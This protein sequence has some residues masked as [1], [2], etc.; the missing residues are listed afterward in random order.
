MD[1]AAGTIERLIERLTEIY[2]EDSLCA[3]LVPN[4]FLTIDPDNDIHIGRAESPKERAERLLN[5]VLQRGDAD[6][7]KLLDQLE[8]LRPRFPALSGVLER[9]RKRHTLIGIIKQHKHSKLTLR[10]I[11]DIGEENMAQCGPK[12][13]QDLPLTLLRKLAALERT[14][15]DTLLLESDTV[16]RGEETMDDIFGVDAEDHVSNSI[17]SLDVLCVLLNCSDLFLQQEI[18]SKMSLCQFAVPLLLPA[19]DGPECTFM[20]W[21]MR[22]IVRSWRPQASAGSRAF[23]EESLVN[24]PMPLFSFVR[25]GQSKLSKSKILNQVFSPTQQY[26]DFFIHENMA[27]GNIDRQLS[28]GLVEISWSFPV[29]KQT[30]LNFPEPI[31]VTN[32]HGNLELNKSQLAFLMQVSAAV[33]VFA[34]NINERESETLSQCSQSG[35]ELYF[36]ITPNGKCISREAAQ[37]FKKCFALMN[38]GPKNIVMKD[39]VANDAELV[40][41]IR[42]IMRNILRNPCKRKTLEDMS[43]SATEFGFQVDE[44]C[45][46]CQTAKAHATQITKEIQDVVQYKK[47]TLKLQG[48]LWKEVS[49]TEKELCRMRKQGDLTIKQYKSLLEKKLLELRNQQNRHPLPTGMTLF[50]SAITHFSQVEKHYFLKWMKFT[51]DSLTRK[52]ILELRAEYKEKIKSEMNKADK[53]ELLQLGQQISDSSLGIEHFLR[54]MGQFYESEYSMVKTKQIS[55]T[56]QFTDLP[57]VAAD[58]LLDGFPLELMD[59]DASNIPMQWVTGILTELDNKTGGKCRMRVISVLGVQSTGKSTLLNTMFGLQ[60]PVASGRCTRGAFMTLINVKENLV[61][62]L[63]CEFVLVIDTEGLKAPELASLED[64]YE[65]DNELAT[66]VV[67]L[68]DITITNIAG[69]NSVDMKDILQIVVHAFLRMKTI[70]EKPKCQFVHQNV[71]DVSAND[72]NMRDRTKILEQLNEMTRTAANMEKISGITGFHDIMDYNLDLDSW[73]IPGLWYGVPPM[74]SVSSGYSEN[75]YEL[76]KHLFEFMEKAKSIRQPHNIGDFIEWIKGL[77]N[78]VKHENFIFSF[79][80]S[81]VAEAYNHLAMK[82]S[83]WEWDFRKE[84]QTWLISTEN[85]MKNQSADKLQPGLCV[86]YKD[87]L[88]ILLCEEEKKM[89]DNLERYFESKSNNVHLIERYR[90]DFSQD[91][92]CLRKEMAQSATVKVDDVFRIQTQKYQLQDIQNNYQRTIEENVTS[93]LEKF[94]RNKDHPGDQEVKD[95]F[96]SM[97]ERTLSELPRNPLEKRNISQEMLQEIRIDMANRG[98]SINEKILRVKDLGEFGKKEFKVTESHV[99]IRWYSLI[100]RAK[101]RYTKEFNDKI[102]ALASFL[103]RS[104]SEYVTEKVNTKGDFDRTYCR[105]LLHKISSRLSEKEFQN[106]HFTHGFELDI[107][108]HILGNAAPR[109]QVMHD[110]FLRENDPVL[111]LQNLKPHYQLL[112]KIIF[113]KKDETQSRTRQFC[114]LC[115]KPAIMKH[116]FQHIGNDIV[117]DILDSRNGTE[118]RSR[119]FFQFS[120]LKKLLEQQDFSQFVLYINSYQWFVK[121]WIIDHILDRYSDGQKLEKLQVN[122]LTRICKDI[123]EVLHSPEL[124]NRTSV[125]DFLTQFCLM[126][127]SKLV[128]PQETIKVIVFQNNTDIQQFSRD[129]EEFLTDTEKAMESELKSYRTED[130]LFNASVKPEEELFKKVFGCGKQC[131]FCKAPCEAGGTDHKEHFASVHQ[132]QGLGRCTSSYY[133]NWVHRFQEMYNFDRAHALPHVWGVEK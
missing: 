41:K 39:K 32:M 109:F 112:F 2:S 15:R 38:V 18:F 91:V 59:G 125:S 30:P 71:S 81:L 64:S 95:T 82:Y 73:Y 111:C 20:L 16:S 133:R 43:H 97:W 6:Y 93:L 42:D 24:I 101:E 122:I 128:I 21:A 83:Q 26:N 40:N 35:T 77:W 113:K 107:K 92:K 12:S 55:P 50:I 116:I 99:D 84:V 10:D 17:N 115:L 23:T 98:S 121:R 74:A 94:R 119:T 114:E 124:L 89:L 130:V 79:R 106:L 37:S 90:A 126:L 1:P 80:N 22:D 34:E 131:P 66:L 8:T 56:R 49:Q 14:A 33:F 96:E 4:S 54:E 48:D 76:K 78:S 117:D 72:K 57:K 3:T 102:H 103:I 68:S 47:E 110:T 52:I 11:L 31:A 51:L 132:P 28:N 105:E 87:Y 104:C 65:H 86:G 13:I 70:R 29:G 67:G 7:R 44:S 127:E 63:G 129:I 9:E 5:Y 88:N 60:F 58:L 100:E 27:G 19:G 62:N 36:I 46:D 45:S 69:E 123:R 108:L 85:S 25:L 120:V 53:V 118:Y 61:K 75:V